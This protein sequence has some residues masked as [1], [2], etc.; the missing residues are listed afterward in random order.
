MF[1]GFMKMAEV[2]LPSARTA[3]P[4]A[5]LRGVSF[6]PFADASQGTSFLSSAHASFVEDPAISATKIQKLPAVVEIRINGGI[7]TNR[8]KGQLLMKMRPR[9]FRPKMSTRQTRGKIDKYSL[10]TTPQ[11]RSGRCS[12]PFRRDPTRIDRDLTRS[13]RRCPIGPERERRYAA[14]EFIKNVRNFNWLRRTSQF[15][16]DARPNPVL[17][18]FRLRRRPLQSLRGSGSLPI[19]CV[20]NHRK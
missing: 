15:G 4:M 18:P 1:A 17:P 9:P 2:P 5:K 14:S 16:M 20:Q 6:S 12:L 19:T 3:P 8:G 13:S 11:C 10:L 7:A